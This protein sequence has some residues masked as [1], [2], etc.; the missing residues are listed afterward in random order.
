MVFKNQEGMVI[1]HGDF[2]GQLPGARP[3]H[4]PPWRAPWQKDVDG[5]V[6]DVNRL[7]MWAP[8]GGGNSNI[9]YFHPDPWGRLPF[10]RA[11]F[12]NGLKP[13][14]RPRFLWFFFVGDQLDL[15]KVG[16]LSNPNSDCVM[17][18]C[19][20]SFGWQQTQFE[21]KD[22]GHPKIL[23]NSLPN[24]SWKKHT[25]QNKAPRW[26]FQYY[27]VILHIFWRVHESIIHVLNEFP[28]A[29]IYCFLWLIVKVKGMRM[30]G[31]LFCFGWLIA[32]LWEN[33]SVSRPDGD[34]ASRFVVA[35]ENTRMPVKHIVIHSSLVLYNFNPLASWGI[36][37]TCSSL[38]QRSAL[39]GAST[40]FFNDLWFWLW[41]PAVPLLV[42]LRW[43]S[44]MLEMAKV[45][46]TSKFKWSHNIFI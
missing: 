46:I 7:N 38:L 25:I 30:W 18:R 34:E 28:V 23:R 15:N 39:S 1:C 14:T 10:W 4:F 43:Q 36:H 11:Y 44:L 6:E 42:S 9:F 21:G 45:F 27:A 16:E 17:L 20:K 24:L 40:W 8:L 3:V 31:V 2:H 29:S 26:F 33:Q 22:V 13:P 19:E 5:E 41:N 12:S 35:S 32:T 37:P